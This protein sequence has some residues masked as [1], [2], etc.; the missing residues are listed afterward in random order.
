MRSFLGKVRDWMKH[1]LVSTAHDFGRHPISAEPAENPADKRADKIADV[2]EA[3]AGDGPQIVK[4]IK[5]AIEHPRDAFEKLHK[6][7]SGTIGHEPATWTE[8]THEIGHSLF[9]GVF[10]LFVGVAAR[11]INRVIE[12]PGPEE[13]PKDNPPQLAKDKDESAR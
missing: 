11:V 5:H 12:S 7:E 10:G 1:N 8:V 9:A 3:V 6:I 13:R 2:A 4:G